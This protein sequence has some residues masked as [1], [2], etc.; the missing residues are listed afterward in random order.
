MSGSLDIRHL[1]VDIAGSPILIDVVLSIAPG[2]FVGL[3]GRNGAGKTTLMR[4]IMGLLPA[5]SG[6]VTFVDKYLRVMPAQ[7]RAHLDIGYMPE[8]RRL[9]PELTVEENVLLPAW[10][11]GDANFRE[12]LEFVYGILPE[13]QEFAPRRAL[14]LSGGQQKLVALARALICGRRLLLLDE[15]FEGVAPALARRLAEAIAALKATGVSVLLSES[16]YVHSGD[17]VDSL[18]VIERGVVT[19]RFAVRS[20]A[21]D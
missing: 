14:Q 18:Y 6:E 10:A 15:P 21:S 13:V 2:S 7:A 8:D 1:S 9:I 19:P 12:R 3:I 17:L 4:A 20:S 11:I 16:D 5:R